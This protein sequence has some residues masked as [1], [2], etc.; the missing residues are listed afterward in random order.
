M[1]TPFNSDED[2]SRIYDA[3]ASLSHHEAYLRNETISMKTALPE[4]KYQPYELL[5]ALEEEIN[6]DENCIGRICVRCH[7][8]CPPAILPIVPGEVINAQTITI[9]KK[10]DIRTI[11]VLKNL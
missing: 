11:H 10:Y 9:L 1:L 7:I 4:V 2:L 3:F 5:F 8:G 6:V